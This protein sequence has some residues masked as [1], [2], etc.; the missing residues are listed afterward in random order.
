L[1]AGQAPAPC[2]DESEIRFHRGDRTEHRIHIQTRL[3]DDA[4]HAEGIGHEDPRDRTPLPVELSRLGHGSFLLG[5]AA[6]GA[7]TRRRGETERHREEG[8]G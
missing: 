3:A 8:D 7:G 2:A 5:R 6:T 4:L 1:Q